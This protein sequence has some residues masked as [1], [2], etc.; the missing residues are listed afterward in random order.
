MKPNEIKTFFNY[1]FWAFERVWDCI[2]QLTDEQFVQ[3]IDYSTGSI[4]EHV[5]HLASAI[6]RR[7][8]QMQGKDI[9]PHLSNK[10]FPTRSSFKS[11]WDEVRNEAYEYL[12]TISET[13]LDGKV[14]GTSHETGATIEITRWEILMHVVNHAT[15]HRAQILAM[16]HHHF[17]VKTVGQDMMAFLAERDQ[18]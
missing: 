16:L 14:Q 10:D 3:N 9:P 18:N 6:H 8:Q 17:G 7:I 13:D 15:D 12:S 1:N 11:K 4:Q 5:V 2:L